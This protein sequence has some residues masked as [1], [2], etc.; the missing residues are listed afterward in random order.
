V[1][2]GAVRAFCAAHSNTAQLVA[3][4]DGGGLLNY[5][6]IALILAQITDPD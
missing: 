2:I 6:H 4:P 3:V 5:T 1:P